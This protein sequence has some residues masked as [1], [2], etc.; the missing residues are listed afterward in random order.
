LE[1]WQSGQHI[2]HIIQ[3]R[4]F[5]SIHKHFSESGTLVGEVC[6]FLT[7][8]IEIQYELVDCIFHMHVPH[9][10]PNGILFI[11]RRLLLLNTCRSNKLISTLDLRL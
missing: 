10:C 3:T 9:T 5:L 4:G 8:F 11:K 6:V 7:K 1:F 2:P